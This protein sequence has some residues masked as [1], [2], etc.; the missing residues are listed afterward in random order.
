MEQSGSGSIIRIRIRRRRAWGS[1]RRWETAGALQLHA[2]SAVDRAG[3]EYRHTDPLLRQAASKE[4]RVAT[5]PLRTKT[6]TASASSVPGFACA[7]AGRCR[8]AAGPNQARPQLV[9]GVP[10][11]TPS[12]VCASITFHHHHT[13]RAP[14]HRCPPAARRPPPAARYSRDTI[15]CTP[16]RPAMPARPS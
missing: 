1:G 9:A 16:R 7:R 3:D 10:Q 14:P 6:A 2:A 13:T 15:I 4:E 11:A 8:L 12:C 5:V